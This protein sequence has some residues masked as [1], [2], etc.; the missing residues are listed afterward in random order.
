MVDVNFRHFQTEKHGS[1]TVAYR[2]GDRNVK[3]DGKLFEVGV[4]FCSPLEKHFDKKRGRLIAIGRLV[5]RRNGYVAQ[6]LPFEPNRPPPGFLLHYL[7]PLVA[8]PGWYLKFLDKLGNRALLNKYAMLYAVHSVFEKVA[9]LE[10]E[11]VSAV[12]FNYAG[13]RWRASCYNAMSESRV[14]L[15][16]E[17]KNSILASTKEAGKISMKLREALAQLRRFYPLEEEVYG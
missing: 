6:K 4:A 1:I 15:V 16:E 7:L 12:L 8:G 5:A 9:N 11:D 13:T 14:P 17:V 10:V 2:F 3:D